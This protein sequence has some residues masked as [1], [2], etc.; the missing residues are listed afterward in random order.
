MNNEPYLQNMSE[1]PEQ[2]DIKGLIKELEELRMWKEETPED[3]KS[4]DVADNKWKVRHNWFQAILF[5]LNYFERT[6][7]D[8]YREIEDPLKSDIEQFKRMCKN[9][10]FPNRLTNRDEIDLGNSTIEEAIEILNKTLQ[11]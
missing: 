10:E 11:N 9:P 5:A 2:Q 7:P 6:L 4:G 8:I 1:T 3:L